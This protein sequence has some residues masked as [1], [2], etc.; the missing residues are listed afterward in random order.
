MPEINV[1]QQNFAAG[2]LSP[3]MRGRFDLPI[4]GN[5]AERFENFIAETQGPARFRTGS[6]FVLN[7]RRN[8]VGVLIPFQFNDSQSYMLEFTEG[9]MRIHKDG[10]VVVESSKT[11]TGATAANPVVITSNGHG[12]SNG[13]E[14]LISGIVGMTELN[15]RSFIVTNK[16]ANTFELYDN[17][18]V[19]VNGTTFTAYAS[20]GIAERVVEIT[21]PYLEEDLFALKYTQ[22]ADTMYIAHQSY[23]PR[24]LTRSSH[25]SWALALYSRTSDPFLAKKTI[26]GITAASPGVVTSTAHGLVSGDEIIIETVVGMT[27]INSKVY[28]VVAINAD[29]FSLTY[30]G[31]AVNTSAYT[32]YVSGGYASKQNL[33]PATVAFYE[34]RLVFGATEAQP[35]TMWG[36]RTPTSAG[37]ARYDDYTTGTDADHAYIFTLAPTSGKVNRIEWFVGTSK[38]MAIGTFGELAKAD[39]GNSDESIT[40]TNINVRP[41]ANTG[42]SPVMPVALGNALLFVQRGGL[43]LYSAEYSV[44][45]D[46]FEAVDRNL[47]AE[48]MTQSGVKQMVFI[49]GRPETIYLVRNDGVL[50][51]LTFKAKEDVSGWTRHVTGGT[52]GVYLSVGVTPRSDEPDRPWVIV[53]R[54]IGL[55]TRRSVE[56]FAD[57]ASIPEKIEYNTGDETVDD[58]RWRRAMF[59]AQKEY[60]HVDSALTFD[61]SDLGADANVT[62]TPAAVTGTDVIFTASGA[63]FKSSMVGREIWRK[64]IDGVGYGRARII[65][66]TDTTH[67]HC[68]ILTDFNSTSVIPAGEWYLTSDEITGLWH[69]EGEEVAVISDGGDHPVQTV[70]DGAITL[71]YQVSKCHVGLAYSGFIKSMNIEAGGVTGPAQTKP[72]NINRVGIKFLNTL[73]AKFGT[74]PY[75]M[76]AV[77][78]RSSADSTNRPPPLFSGDMSLPFEDTTSLEKHICIQQ[79]KPL[80]CI[81]LAV[82]P[83]V[84]TDNF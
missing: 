50:L 72:K 43:T 66:Y 65:T 13:D 24:K 62:V 17:D 21:T 69:L 14:V 10:G 38:F 35:E 15:G 53:E 46:S 34:S 63:I 1:S 55:T 73:G 44:L 42:V 6:I 71:D 7:T 81:I 2:E 52:D 51:I 45:S 28:T 23:E 40:P 68:R 41:I 76:E 83:Y 32:A 4:Y 60:I 27:Q 29:T 54:T 48:H 78:F 58:A 3:K 16:A 26:T 75:N 31:V 49:N 70:D 47:V 8:H 39:G 37:V 12:Y 18:A 5:G 59:E 36:S 19:A 84:D 57:V 30:E 20:G 74:T 82:L 67:V 80:P 77:G 11:I 9:Y 33:L 56:Y 25:T 22:N 64:S 61:G 79:V